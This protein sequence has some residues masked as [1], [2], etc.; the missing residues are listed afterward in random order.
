MSWYDEAWKYRSAI[1]IVNDGLG[2]GTDDVTIAVA[3]D[4][5][6]FWD[7]IQSDGDDIRITS[8]DGIT[9]ETYQL[10]GFDFANKVLTIECDAVA[11][12]GSAATELIWL[13]YGNSAAVAASGTFTAANALTGHIWLGTPPEGNRVRLR[14]ERPEATQPETEFAK[15]TAEELWLWILVPLMQ[16]VEANEGQ[17]AFEEVARVANTNLVKTGGSDVTSTLADATATKFVEDGEGFWV[18]IS[19]QDAGADGTDYSI[20]PR[21]T[22]QIGNVDGQRRILNPRILMKVRDPDETA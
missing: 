15:T 3:V 4:W 18:G 14:R 12:A 21:I 5:D 6:H 10:I 2:G 16:R 20:E 1:G 22:T 8:A 9:L 19:L 7:N 17:Q 11:M 13:Y